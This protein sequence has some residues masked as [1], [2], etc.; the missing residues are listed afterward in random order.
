MPS[1]P[2]PAE[3]L[4]IRLAP[5]TG[6]PEAYHTFTDDTDRAIQATAQ[7][8]DGELINA[9]NSDRQEVA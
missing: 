3:H 1:T 2:R 8:S 9:P 5:V 4:T 7:Q 6:S